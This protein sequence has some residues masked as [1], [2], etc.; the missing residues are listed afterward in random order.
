MQYVSG[1]VF[2][3]FRCGAAIPTRDAGRVAAL[4][5]SSSAEVGCG[6]KGSA[7]HLAHQG[8]ELEG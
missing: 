1:R 4:A 2:I 6:T 3:L 5:A 7:N 8:D